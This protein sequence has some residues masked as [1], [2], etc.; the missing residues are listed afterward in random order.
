MSDPASAGFDGVASPT[1]RHIQRTECQ[2]TR[3]VVTYLAAMLSSAQPRTMSLSKTHTKQLLALISKR[4]TLSATDKELIPL[5]FKY[6][7]VQKGEFVTHV[8]ESTPILYMVME[9]MLRVYNIDENGADATFQFAKRNHWTGDPYSLFTDVSSTV[10]IEALEDSEL[11]YI[12]IE[13]LEELYREVPILERYFRIMYQ[14]AYI[15]S[16][17]R[18]HQALQDNASVRYHKLLQS[19]PDLFEKASLANIASYLGITP[20]SL[21]RIRK[22][23]P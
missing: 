13:E 3:K 18:I 14:D 5:R 4:V 10:E 22:S 20:E 16:M 7:R 21:S 2:Q 12:T 6:R 15:F 9:G 19:Y 17:R 11:I 1:F 23:K 8:G